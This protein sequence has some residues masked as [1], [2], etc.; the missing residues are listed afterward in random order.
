MRREC[1]IELY[2]AFDHDRS[3]FVDASELLKMGRQG[4]KQSGRVK[5]WSEAQNAA[6]VRAMDSSG[7]GRICAAEFVQFCNQHFPRDNTQFLLLCDHFRE[8]A[9]ERTQ[10]SIGRSKKSAVVQSGSVMGTTHSEYLP[11]Y[12]IATKLFHIHHKAYQEK[13]TQHAVKEKARQQR[14]V[15]DEKLRSHGRL[16]RRREHQLHRRAVAM[17]RAWKEHEH[18]PESSSAQHRFPLPLGGS[19]SQTDRLPTQGVSPPAT[20]RP[21]PSSLPKQ[22]PM[23]L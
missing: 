10:K 16:R 19:S 14:Q 4:Y 2:R 15:V 3:G 7:D 22:R 13:A 6:L 8:A 21:Q 11:K 23:F 9:Q 18:H 5:P 12:G 1:L 20:T 17:A